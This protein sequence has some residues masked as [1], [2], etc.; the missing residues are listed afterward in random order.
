MVRR[1]KK[2]TIS[3]SKFENYHFVA[4]NFL[5]GA[6]VASEFEYWNAAGVLIVHSA[7]A[8]G[9]AVT[10]K[11]GSVKSKGDDHR[12]ITNLLNTMLIHSEEKKKALLQLSKI[13]DHKNL[14][15]YSG[16]I[17]YKKDIDKL[18]IYLKRF[19]IWAED[20]LKN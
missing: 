9:D 14:V 1:I 20:I 17:Y 15:S 18:W 16:D 5:N 6:E 12:D 2:I 7:I 10:I 3:K 4:Q 19:T 11:F 8:Y 13:L